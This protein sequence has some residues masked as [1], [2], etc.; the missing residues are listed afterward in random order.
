MRS[1]LLFQLHELLRMAHTQHLSGIV[2]LREEEFPV[3][4]VEAAGY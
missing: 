1:Q 4:L 2:V 3:V